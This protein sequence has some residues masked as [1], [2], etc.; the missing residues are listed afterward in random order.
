MYSL[1]QTTEAVGL[2]LV[3]AAGEGKVLFFNV[4]LNSLNKWW[5]EIDVYLVFFCWKLCVLCWPGVKGILLFYLL[6]II[7]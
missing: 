3:E 7:Y 2:G 5:K 1:Q 4:P 6:N